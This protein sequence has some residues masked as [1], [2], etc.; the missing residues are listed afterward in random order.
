MTKKDFVKL[1]QEHKDKFKCLVLRDTTIRR[2]YDHCAVFIIWNTGIGHRSEVKN[3]RCKE[4]DLKAIETL[5]KYK[6]WI[7]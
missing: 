5:N 7:P 6:A 2:G 3:M 1:I 4:T